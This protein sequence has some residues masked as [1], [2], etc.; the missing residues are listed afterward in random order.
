MSRGEDACPGR[1]YCASR[2]TANNLSVRATPQLALIST[3]SA[4][5]RLLVGL[6]F[7]RSDSQFQRSGDGQEASARG[8]T[9]IRLP[10]ATRQNQ[11]RIP[12]RVP[13]GMRGFAALSAKLG[14]FQPPT[15]LQTVLQPVP[16]PALPAPASPAS[17]NFCSF[18]FVA[19]ASVCVASAGFACRLDCRLHAASACSHRTLRCL[20]YWPPPALPAPLPPASPLTNSVW[21][22]SLGDRHV[23]NVSPRGQWPV[24]VAVPV[25]VE[26][27]FCSSLFLLL[28][29][30]VSFVLLNRK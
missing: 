27:V 25:P 8:A 14:T 9:L 29:P 18:V 13:M 3:D 16:V 24:P 15:Q 20:F 1:A 17:F 6:L 2:R 21:S 23:G 10:V 30:F 5:A 4:A 22:A 19:V 26:H 28:L 12:K 11:I 7:L